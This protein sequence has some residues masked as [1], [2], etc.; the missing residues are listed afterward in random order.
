MESETDLRRLLGIPDAIWLGQVTI[1]MTRSEL[2][3]GSDATV[4]RTTYNGQLVATKVIHRSLIAPENTARQAF[5]RRFGEECLRLR[6]LSHPS[7]VNFIGVGQAPNSCPCLVLEL[8]EASL[9]QRINVSPPDPFQQTLSYLIDMAAG[10]RYLH[11]Q[12]I[13]HRD[14]KPQNILICAGAA[15]IADVGMARTLHGDMVVPQQ[16]MTRCPGT[17]NYMPPESLV[18]GAAYDQ[19]LD[20]FACGVIIL[21]MF[22]NKEPAPKVRTSCMHRKIV[23]MLSM[24]SGNGR[25]SSHV[26][27]T[28]LPTRDI[29]INI[30]IFV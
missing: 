10:L 12:G 24:S 11:W 25:F 29:H 28:S 1:D 9:A 23:L 26:I 13:V 5:I 27:F 22:T 6:Q 7:V 2:G 8:M 30:S 3:V 4:Y 14:L 17:P 19:S 16:R 18:E 21:A 15:K 20:I